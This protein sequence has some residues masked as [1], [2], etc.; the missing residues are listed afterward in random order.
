MA[1]EIRVLLVEEAKNRA[2]LSR[3]L[4]NAPVV[5]AGEAGFGTEAVTAAR[6]IHPNV[7]VLGLE[8]P[9]ARSIRTIEMLNLAVPEAS[10]VVASSV[11]DREVMRRAMRAGARDYL[12]K[13]I[14]RDDLSRAVLAVFEV[15]QRKQGLSGSDRSKLVQTGDVFVI[16]GA[17]GGIGKTT[18]A[19]NLAAAIAAETEQR[20]ALV[21]LDLQM[22]DVAL[23]LSVSPERSIVDATSNVERLEAEYLQNLV[24]ADRS[25]VRVLPAPPT[26]EES[27]EVTADQV[28]GVLDA[29]S[30]TFDYTVV[31]TSPSLSEIN[32]RALEKATLILQM[33]TPELAA[34]KRA[35]VSLGLMRK[36]WQFPDERIKLLLNFP[37]EMPGVAISE[38][39]SSLD[40]PVFWKIPYDPAVGQAVRIGRPCV[41]SRQNSR[42]SKNISELA[43]SLCGLHRPSRG[44]FRILWQ[45]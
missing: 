6:D 43:R 25:G 29:L 39:E 23:F 1:N 40:F 18:L 11:N 4:A 20:V 19:V 8:E 7:I 33:T 26:P 30:R 22:G 24:Y 42:F 32:L 28:G 31:D 9:L 44:V 17:K 14:G 37:Y 10:I 16:S 15:E 38:I 12:S 27:I 3:A 45:R 35:K 34:L 5:V 21:D 13:P 41:E 2:Q 36:T